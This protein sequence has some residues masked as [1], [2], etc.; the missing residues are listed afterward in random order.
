M[1]YFLVVCM[2]ECIYVA[3]MYRIAKYVRL[4]NVDSKSHYNYWSFSEHIFQLPLNPTMD[5]INFHSFTR[6]SFK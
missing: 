1:K 2:Y 6:F 5:Q 4:K 3:Q